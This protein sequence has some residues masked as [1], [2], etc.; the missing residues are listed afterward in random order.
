MQ[1][2]DCGPFG[3]ILVDDNLTNVNVDQL[4]KTLPK[5]PGTRRSYIMHYGQIQSFLES[6]LAGIRVSK[7]LQEV[8]D[9]NRRIAEMSPDHRRFFGGLER[10]DMDRIHQVMCLQDLEVLS[11]QKRAVVCPKFWKRRYI[12]AAFVFSMHGR[13]IFRLIK[14]GLYVY[15]GKPTEEEEAIDL[16]GLEAGNG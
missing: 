8:K 5:A 2:L 4:I 3:K 14:A 16:L 12:P 11:L 7:K 13:T 9:S 10:M 6:A 15:R 1:E